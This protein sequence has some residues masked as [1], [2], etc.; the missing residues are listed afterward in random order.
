LEVGNAILASILHPFR[1]GIH[2]SI[3]DGRN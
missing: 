1:P 2:K 3:S